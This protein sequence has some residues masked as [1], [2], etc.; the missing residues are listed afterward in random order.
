MVASDFDKNLIGFK[1]SNR[2]RTSSRFGWEGMIKKQLTSSG[3]STFGRPEE[4]VVVEFRNGVL[5]E[6]SI[7]A[8]CRYLQIEITKEQEMPEIKRGYIVW[9]THHNAT[10]P[11]VVHPTKQEA[12]KE[13][14]RLAASSPSIQFYVAKLESVSSVQSVIT[15]DL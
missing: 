1:V 2:N 7:W 5:Q 3:H 11:K 12:Q 4:T 6:Y 10:N 15:T 14:Q 13:A 8:A 9:N